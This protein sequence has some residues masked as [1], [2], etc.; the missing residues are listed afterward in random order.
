MGAALQIRKQRTS[1]GN[2]HKHKQVLLKRSVSAHVH[3]ASEAKRSLSPTAWRP[4]FRPV[5]LCLCAYPCL[6][7]ITW[8]GP[9]AHRQTE[10]SQRPS[11]T[12]PPDPCKKGIAKLSSSSGLFIDM[13]DIDII[14][15]FL[16]GAVVSHRVGYLA[17][18]F[19]DSS[20]LATWDGECYSSCGCS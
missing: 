8:A 9:P 11:V 14:S 6:M 20:R 19:Q 2:K 12:T 17:P 15:S 16:L 5:V 1:K 13:I 3:G 10:H 7:R 4:A 18:V